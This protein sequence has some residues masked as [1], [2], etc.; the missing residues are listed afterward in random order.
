MERRS[1]RVVEGFE[2][3]TVAAFDE[4]IELNGRRPIQVKI[5]RPDG[6]A[7]DAVA[8]SE[9]LLMRVTTIIEKSALLLQD[10]H[11]DA[12]PIGSIITLR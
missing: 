11:K 10:I 6:A 4:I 8:F 1:Y 5:T 7:F 12:V 9:R 3:G 2:R